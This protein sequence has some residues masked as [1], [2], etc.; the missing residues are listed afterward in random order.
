MSF[1]EK[2]TFGP[3]IEFLDHDKSRRAQLAAIGPRTSQDLRTSFDLRPETGLQFFLPI[4]HASQYFRILRRSMSNRRGYSQ[5]SPSAGP[6][7]GGTPKKMR[8]L[9]TTMVILHRMFISMN[10]V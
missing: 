3:Y 9:G 5:A 1:I 4:Y 7:A 10:P 2:Y 6:N 8:R